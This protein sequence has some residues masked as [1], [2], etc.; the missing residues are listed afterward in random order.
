MYLPQ[1]L[2]AFEC[3]DSID[4][5]NLDWIVPQKW[6]FLYSWY[7]FYS[8][9]LSMSDNSDDSVDCFD[10]ADCIDFVDYMDFAGYAD[11]VH[12]MDFGF[13]FVAECYTSFADDFDLI[14]VVVDVL[15]FRANSLLK[16]I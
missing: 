16:W 13:D 4:Q 1:T 8:L 14:V 11:S 7:V 9:W 2:K 15:W 12:C 3:L 6:D 10:S 5:V